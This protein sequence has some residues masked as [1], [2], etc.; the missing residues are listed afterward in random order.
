MERRLDL[1]ATPE[2]GGPCDE[3]RSTLSMVPVVGSE[4]VVACDGVLT[5]WDTATGDMLGAPLTLG[6][7]SGSG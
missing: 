4:L 3:A 1:P 2:P 7:G 6:A 5:R